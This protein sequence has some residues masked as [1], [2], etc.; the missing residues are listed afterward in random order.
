MK[1]I[2]PRIVRRTDDYFI[3]DLK[4]LEALFLKEAAALRVPPNSE[5][6]KAIAQGYELC[7][8]ILRH[9]KWEGKKPKRAAALRTTKV[10]GWITKTGK[11]VKGYTR[12]LKPLSQD[13]PVRVKA[14]TKKRLGKKVPIRKHTR[15]ARGDGTN[16]HSREAQS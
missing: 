3:T 8:D 15:A 12:T 2:L 14:H 10:K 7:A 11:K 6:D 9:T 1:Q 16:S 5:T 13:K 4:Q